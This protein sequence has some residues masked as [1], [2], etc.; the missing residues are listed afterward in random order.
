M[1]YSSA[2]TAMWNSVVQFG[3]I[4]LSIL[5][6]NIMRRKVGFIRRSYIPT[7]VL[8]GFLILIVKTVGIYVPDPDFLDFITYHGIAIGF[9][10]LSLRVNQKTDD[11]KQGLIPLKSGALIVSTYLIQGILGLTVTLLLGS[12]VFPNLFTAS[13]L[14]L[15]MGYGQGP[16]QANN[17]GATYEALGFSGGHSFALA[18]AAAG[19]LCACLVG[20]VYINII[21]KKGKADKVG[22]LPEATTEKDQFEDEGEIPVSSSIDKLSIQVSLVIF[23][24]LLTYTICHGIT[25]LLQA[26]APGLAGTVVP[27]LWGFNFIVGSLM[28]MLVRSAMAGLRAK[29]IMNHQYQNNYLLSR[30]SGLA[31]DIM[32]IGGIASINVE[33][34]TGLW[35]PF[36]ILAVF[37]GAVTFIYLRFM[38][39]KLY[40]SYKEEGFVSMFGMLTGTISSG[41]L[42]LR[43]LDPTFKTPASS[44][45][46][47]GSSFAIA[48][49]APMLLFISI[50]AQSTKHAVI[51]LGFLVIYLAVLVLLILKL[52]RKNKSKGAEE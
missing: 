49:G 42:L 27:L 46:L 1:D 44:N 32:I 17:V 36:I 41:V 45:L 22:D 24:Y 19:Y 13:G 20:V 4:A 6:A 37:G 52:R 18:L 48:F 21:A 33:D 2:N 12:F 34:L 40:P 8:A 50:A 30:I 9:I 15:P 26:K 3:V 39:S 47:T 51:T 38:C 14:L 28:A 43:E 16:G 5:I 29:R 35:I 7:A 23:V 11:Q 10:A 31:F 25:V